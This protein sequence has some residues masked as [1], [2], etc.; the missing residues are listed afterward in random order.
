LA[1]TPPYS[2]YKYHGVP[3]VESVKRVRFSPL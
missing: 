1:T 2:S 3:P